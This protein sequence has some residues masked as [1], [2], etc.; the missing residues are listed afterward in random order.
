MRTV[1]ENIKK[2]KGPG[3]PGEET[4]PRGEHARDSGGESGRDGRVE[5]GQ[6]GELTP[7]KRIAA[8]VSPGSGPGMKAPLMSS[9]ERNPKGERDEDR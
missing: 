4:S 9:K 6:T 8:P 3:R 1:E 5:D 7:D 2:R